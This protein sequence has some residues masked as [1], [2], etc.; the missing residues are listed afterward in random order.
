MTAYFLCTDVE[1][2]MNK[3]K[4][5]ERELDGTVSYLCSLALAE[6]YRLAPLV[7]PGFWNR[8]ANRADCTLLIR[9]YVCL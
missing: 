4:L 6:L 5:Q 1:A 7:H 8:R 9:R 3:P 2:S